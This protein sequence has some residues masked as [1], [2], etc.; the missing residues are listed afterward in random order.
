MEY[1]LFDPCWLPVSN[2]KKNSF[3][4]ASPSSNR[5]AENAKKS[6]LIPHQS[7]RISRSLMPPS[8]VPTL[9]SL[10]PSPYVFFF[11]HPFSFPALLVPFRSAERV[12]SSREHPTR[13][14]YPLFQSPICNQQS[15]IHNRVIRFSFRFQETNVLLMAPVSA[16]LS[17]PTGPSA[18]RLPGSG[19]RSAHPRLGMARWENRAKRSIV[20]VGSGKNSLSHSFCHVIILLRARRLRRYE[21][22]YCH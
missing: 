8:M 22:N 11:I 12:D 18:R 20:C 7:S 21:R 14:N 1:G 4:C 19:R 15:T 2:G 3:H 9:S 13:R 10:L 16:P 6:T 5:S 17:S